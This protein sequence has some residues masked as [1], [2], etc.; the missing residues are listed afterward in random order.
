[1]TEEKT[2]KTAKKVQVGVPFK[3]GD[4]WN[5]NALGRPK[6]TK[7]FSTIFEEAIKLIVKEQRIPVKDPE[8][9]MV[10]KAV[11]KALQGNYAFYKDI[12]DRTYGA[13]NNTNVNVG[14]QVNNIQVSDEQIEEEAIEFL[15][16]RGYKCTKD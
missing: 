6:G 11:T 15:Q 8:V 2:E 16:G 1:M 10:V 9:E 5:G 13:T 12:M 14:V 7:N 3:S 4:E